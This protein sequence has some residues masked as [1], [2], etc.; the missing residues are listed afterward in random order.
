MSLLSSCARLLLPALCVLAPAVA[1]GQVSFQ[2]QFNLPLSVAAQPDTGGASLLVTERG[3]NRVHKY[4]TD[5]TLLWRA[6]TVAGGSGTDEFRQPGGLAV[7]AANDRVYVADTGNARIQLL[8]LST[9]ASVG[10]W[11]SYGT[12]PGQFRKPIAVAVDTGV[13]AAAHVYVLDAEL[14]RVQ[15][16]TFDGATLLGSFGGA[17]GSG[18]G[19]FSPI[20]DGPG[21]IVLDTAGNAYISDV[22]NHRIHKWQLQS[23]A[24]GNITSA[25][26]VGWLGKCTSGT[27]CDTTKGQSR[28]FGCTAATCPAGS[29]ASGSGAAQ[30]TNPRGLGLDG[31]GNLFVADVDNNR[32]Q[33]F[34][35]NGAFVR[36]WG[37]TGSGSGQ[38]RGPLDVAVLG[39]DVFVADM[40][41]GR[42]VHY[43]TTGVQQA[44]IGGGIALAAQPGWPPD[45]KDALLDANPFFVVGGE[46]QSTTV[47]VTSLGQFSGP[48]NLNFDCLVPATVASGC[49]D[50]LTDL[51]AAPSGT[52]IFYSSNPANVPSGNDVSS[53]L[54]VTTAPSATPGK[55]LR[56]VRAEN[57][58]DGIRYQIWVALEIIAP[59]TDSTTVPCMGSY[60]RSSVPEILP[61]APLLTSLYHDKHS[62]PSRSGPLFLGVA[63]RATPTA[64][65][66]VTLEKPR[67]ADLPL[68]P[69]QAVVVF[70]NPSGG[71]KGIYAL[72]SADCSISTGMVAEA[73]TT[74]EFRIA[75]S[76][77]TTLY[78]SQ[79]YQD[80][81]IFSEPSFWQFVGGRR[82]TIQWVG[83]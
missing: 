49:L 73:G 20:G 43:S 34:D 54:T 44:V 2:Y 25:T 21:D 75:T 32:I 83:N 63:A 12:G 33:Q 57:M 30:F 46:S 16:F 61:L 78:L 13:G 81:A 72:N 19:A 50:L 79:P 62:N 5:G 37:T 74:A 53:T 55:F 59:P 58:T 45:N 7:I 35:A 1:L 48:V 69:T 51:P 26:F 80:I 6:G 15:K 76:N 22:T 18:D 14:R 66:N 39:S 60:Q 29:P 27:G 8:T 77:T 56:P 65:W 64:G 47:T 11:G 38:F 70:I 28:G 4:R 3:N 9:G 10:R 42:V 23:D 41:N 31:A 36:M 52:T 40:R 24:Q 71:R 68:P 82:V 67:A 17:L